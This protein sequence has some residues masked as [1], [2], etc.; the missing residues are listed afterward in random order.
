MLSRHWNIK[1]A[2]GSIDIVE[3]EGVIGEQP[4]LRANESYKYTS[5]CPLK[6]PFGSMKGFF[7]FSREGG[8]EFKSKIPEFSLVS[9]CNIN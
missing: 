5:F 7:T 2:H 4:T 3:G 9:P 1:D 8:I 6:T